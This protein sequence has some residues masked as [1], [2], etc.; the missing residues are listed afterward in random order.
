MPRHLGRWINRDPIGYWAGSYNLYEYVSGM[1]AVELDP[2]G[3]D[4][5]CRTLCAMGYET[6]KCFTLPQGM[7]EEM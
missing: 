4:K 2:M 1:P 5:W 6:N 7:F 3:L